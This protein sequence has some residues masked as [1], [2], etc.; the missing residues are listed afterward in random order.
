MLSLSEIKM[1][2]H[3]IYFDESIL[4]KDIESLTLI[5]KKHFSSIYYFL[6]RIVNAYNAMS[7]KTEPNYDSPINKIAQLWDKDFIDDYAQGVLWIWKKGKG[8]I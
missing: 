4:E 5:K 8:I 3:N 6:S 1:P 2:W 7:E